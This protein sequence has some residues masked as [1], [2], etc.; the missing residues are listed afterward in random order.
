MGPPILEGKGLKAVNVVKFRFI[1]RRKGYAEYGKCLVSNEMYVINCS[2]QTK[3]WRQYFSACA[4]S[5]FCGPGV[6]RAVAS[7]T[8]VCVKLK[9]KST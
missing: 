6:I 7:Q 3:L 8:S 5:E 4:S 1:F 2:S 9:S